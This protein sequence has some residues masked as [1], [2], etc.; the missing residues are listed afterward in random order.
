MTICSLVIY[1]LDCQTIFTLNIIVLILWNL[2][3]NLVVR[4]GISPD[5]FR[6]VFV[7]LILFYNSSFFPFFFVFTDIQA[8]ARRLKPRAG[9]RAIY[10]YN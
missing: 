1:V 5:S 7:D 6:V 3:E 2:T 8:I 4:M 10:R 9:A